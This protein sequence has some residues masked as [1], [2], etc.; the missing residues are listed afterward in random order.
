[1]WTQT[2]PLVGGGL[3][4]AV[5]DPQRLQAEGRALCKQETN[6]LD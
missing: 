1:M 2:H 4:L 6:N 3:N 5:I